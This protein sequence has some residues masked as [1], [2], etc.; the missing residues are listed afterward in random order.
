M[1]PATSAV[2]E[3]HAP[4]DDRAAIPA[5]PRLVA[6]VVCHG[7][8]QQVQ[9]ETLECLAQSLRRAAGDPACPVRAEVVRL[10][11]MPVP[12]APAGAPVDLRRVEM[13][14]PGEDGPQRVHLYEAYWAP[15]TEG[16]VSLAEVFAF[17]FDAGRSGLW[18]WMTTRTFDRWMFGG[19]VAFAVPVRTPLKLAG[20]V[21]LLL[22]LAV[23]NA[24]LVGVV[25]ARL[26]GA[27]LRW[28]GPAL[29]HALTSDIAI[30]SLA[31]LAVLAGI[32]LVPQLLRPLGGRVAAFVAWTVIYAG[33]VA[34][35]VSGA[36]CAWALVVSQAGGRPGGGWL[37]AFA[38]SLH[39]A[40]AMAFVALVWAPPA[41]AAWVARWFLVQYVGDV[42]A[43]VSAHR[44]SRFADIR[45]A[46]Q[47]VSLR[48]GS[49]VY[50]A[51]GAGGEPL[52]T[53]VIVV[54]HSLGSVVAYDMLNRLLTEDRLAGD[55][56]R[57][58]ERTRMLLTFGSP[59]NKTAYLFRTQR[60]KGSDVR[61]V[62]AA[63]VQPLISTYAN[64][65]MPWLN[66]HS[67]NDW[68]G[69]P[70]DFYDTNPPDP[71]RRVRNVEDEDARTPLAAHSE[72]WQGRRLA[73]ALRAAIVERAWAREGS[74]GPACEPAIAHD[75]SS[76]APESTAALPSRR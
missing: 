54:G 63:A 7:M 70:L 47:E 8:G 50:H 64:R 28:P 3:P 9:F 19:R 42:V 24:V 67:R 65:T 36:L 68:I 58:R 45:N 26:A 12:G 61:E 15:I 74:D 21:L 46:I 18:Q 23:I 59:L 11:P 22:A 38:A 32:R 56:A 33:F 2:L 55:R 72:H 20:I 35:A 5:T 57:V 75:A 76:P 34:V 73:E 30:A 71:E 41:V 31:L 29:F 49:A 48:V 69:G 27:A 66:L 6:V 10:A 52:Y 13:D 4:R 16:R 62:V 40:R 14:L 43:Y 17:L 39:G 37:G 1:T 44:V 25:A 53:D 51:A 60:A